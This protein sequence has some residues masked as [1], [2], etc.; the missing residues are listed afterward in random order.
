MQ[1]QKDHGY[2]EQLRRTEPAH[3]SNA[4]VLQLSPDMHWLKSRVLNTTV[5]ED[6][7][8]MNTSYFIIIDHTTRLHVII[9]KHKVGSCTLEVQVQHP[10]QGPPLV[11]FSIVVNYLDLKDILLVHNSK[12]ARTSKTK[13]ERVILQGEWVI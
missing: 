3:D 9:W 6:Q 13:P 2:V 10:T 11:L 1:G 5:H 12:M 4:Q 8:H 7:I